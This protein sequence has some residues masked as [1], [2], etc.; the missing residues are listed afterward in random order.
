MAVVSNVHNS[1]HQSAFASTLPPTI[2]HKEADT[3]IFIHLIDMVTNGITKIAVWKVDT[4]VLVLALASFNKLCVTG[5]REQWL[6]FGTDKN[7]RNIPVHNI[8]SEIGTEMCSALPGLHACLPLLAEGRKQSAKRGSYVD[9]HQYISTVL[10]SL[11]DDVVRN[12]ERFTCL[13]YSSSTEQT[14]VNM[15]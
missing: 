12:L 4:D 6:L 5:L 13:M 14:E 15:L 8:A 2:K 1:V 3:R 10:R 11:P 7:Y 9:I